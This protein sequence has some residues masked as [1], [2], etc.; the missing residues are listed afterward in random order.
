[1]VGNSAGV[2]AF[3]SHGLGPQTLKNGDFE[4]LMSKALIGKKQYILF[5]FFFDWP[6]QRNKKD[7]QNGRVLV[8]IPLETRVC[9]G[10]L[11]A[12]TG[13]PKKGSVAKVKL[14][15]LGAGLVSGF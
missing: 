9:A 4:L 11:Q 1:M 2:F 3:Y 10:I 7:R 13:L 8:A 12:Q 6:P 15:C 5:Y 14:Y